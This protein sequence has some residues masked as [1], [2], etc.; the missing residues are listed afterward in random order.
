MTPLKHWDSIFNP[1]MFFKERI[2]AYAFTQMKTVEISGQQWFW[3][4]QEET[5]YNLERISI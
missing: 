3:G 2:H 1:D 4:F 5:V